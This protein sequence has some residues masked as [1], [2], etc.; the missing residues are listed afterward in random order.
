MTKRLALVVHRVAA[1][2]FLVADADHP[3]INGET[4][5]VA[6]HLSMV[7][8]SRVRLKRGMARPFR[9]RTDDFSVCPATEIAHE[10]VTDKRHPDWFSQPRPVQYS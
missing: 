9:N 4:A 2:R 1:D 8:Q 10:L 3:A 6:H 7:W 5:A